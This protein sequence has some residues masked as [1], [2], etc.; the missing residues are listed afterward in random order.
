MFRFL[1]NHL[2]GACFTLLKLLVTSNFFKKFIKLRHVSVL[3]EPSSGSVYC[4]AKVTGS[5]KFSLFCWLVV[6]FHI[7][8]ILHGI[9]MKISEFVCMQPQL[10]SMQSA[11]AVLYCQ[12]WPARLNRILPHHR[13]TIRSWAKRSFECF[14]ATFVCNTWKSAN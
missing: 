7:L 3:K 2:Q 5:Y 8:I 12:L 14:N 13:I 1:K 6:I 11:C 4:L 9:T 10:S